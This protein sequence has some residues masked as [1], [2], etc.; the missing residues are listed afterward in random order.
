MASAVEN[1]GPKDLVQSIGRGLARLRETRWDLQTQ[2][3][4][5]MRLEMQI[6]FFAIKTPIAGNRTLRIPALMMIKRVGSSP[7]EKLD[8]DPEP[9]NDD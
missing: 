8:G 4:R 2:P 1:P 5:E 7:I 9:D 6:V 3:L